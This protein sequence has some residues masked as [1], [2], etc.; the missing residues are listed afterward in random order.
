VSKVN[1]ILQHLPG[2]GGGRVI[3]RLMDGPTN[4]SYLVEQDGER[5][6]LRID[7]PEAERLGMNRVNERSVCEALAT[8]G[9]TPAYHW[10]DSVEGVSLRPFIAGRS[11]DREDL[12]KPRTLRRLA[13]VLRR[14]HRLPPVGVRFDAA[15]AI[16][17]YAAQLGTPQAAALAQRAHGLLAEIERNAVAPALC[18]NDLVAGNILETEAGHLLLI[19]WEYA[20]IGD[21]Y[22]DL[23]VVV[24]HHDLNDELADCL[25]SAYLQRASSKEESGRFALQCSFYEALLALWNLRVGGL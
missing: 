3:E 7:K 11:L 10:F 20:A 23:A 2:M 13:D 8:A 22:F 1:E 9:L 21:P 14:L 12:K 25:L 15:G 4:A 18:H 6:V 5:F 16:G 24:R 19:D 17:R